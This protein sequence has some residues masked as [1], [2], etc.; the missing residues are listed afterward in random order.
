[1]SPADR[2]YL[3]ALDGLRAI[4]A[5]WVVV[6]HGT[7]VFLDAPPI[8]IRH[9]YLGV[10]LFFVLSGFVL[11]H[12]YAERFVTH[13]A[14]L[15]R[16]YLVHRIARLWPVWLV[17]LA[18]FAL[19]GEIGH[20]LRLSVDAPRPVDEPGTWALYTF[21]MQSWGITDPER[22]NPPGWSLSYEWAGS[23]LLPLA[24]VAIAR[25]R[26]RR[27][28]LA[29]IALCLLLDAF[30]TQ[31]LG[32]QSIAKH[33]AIRAAAELLTGVLLWRTCRG[34]PRAQ[35]GTD[36]A[37]W[38][39]VLVLLALLMAAPQALW[40]DHALVVMLVILV[41]LAAR[42]TGGFAKALS[43]TPLRRFGKASYA[44]YV[45]HYLVL[46]CLWWGFEAL[47]PAPTAAI[48]WSFVLGLIALS[49]LAAATLHLLVEKPARQ[50]LRR[51]ARL[52]DKQQPGMS[53]A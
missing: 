35:A 43:W 29:L 9:G 5:L 47:G 24:L 25:L 3:P 1:L 26:S 37:A 45:V 15:Y 21:L 32:L 42:G 6:L 33:G 27:L 17:V 40:L 13:G 39:C 31:A 8:L 48:G 49:L 7:T 4:A 11:A 34:Q 12:V 19:Q 14:R 22:I 18:L 23:L 28:C 16:F 36:I 2:G 52:D 41:G 10:D 38:C 51:H 20:A 30:Y 44:L 50:A 46:E 53:T